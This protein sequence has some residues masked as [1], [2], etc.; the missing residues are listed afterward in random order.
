MTRATPS[1]LQ[2]PCVRAELPP[3]LP[4]GVDSLVCLAFSLS[5][6]HCGPL[7]SLPFLHQL[8]GE[9]AEW[10]LASRHDEL[11]IITAGKCNMRVWDL[12]LVNRKVLH[13]ISLARAH[14][15]TSP[16]FSMLFAGWLSFLRSTAFRNLLQVKIA[17]V[18]RW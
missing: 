6:F 1:S 16:R 17:R 5:P 8:V 4:R 11:T 9:L 18:I 2:G 3:P 10:G 14:E 7:G 13:P 15:Q 12:D